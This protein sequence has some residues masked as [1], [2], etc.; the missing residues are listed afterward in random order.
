MAQMV[1]KDSARDR[2]IKSS[3]TLGSPYQPKPQTL[4]A[5]S[6]VHLVR[7]GGACSQKR[8]SHLASSKMDS[9]VR[10][11]TDPASRI[12]GSMVTLVCDGRLVPPGR[13]FWT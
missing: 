4:D 1:P 13:K 8:A 12:V 9:S 10:G 3:G 7:N 6:M 11:G 2:A 5:D